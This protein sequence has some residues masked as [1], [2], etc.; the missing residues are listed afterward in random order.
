MNPPQ[1]IQLIIRTTPPPHKI[2]KESSSSSVEMAVLYKTSQKE[3]RTKE[4]S[5]SSPK[6]WPLVLLLLGCTFGSILFGSVHQNSSASVVVV[7]GLMVLAAVGVAVAVAVIGVAGLV[8]WI[9]VVVFLWLIGRSRRRL[10]A[11]G[12]K[13]SK[14]V[15]VGFMVRVLLKEGNV[16]GAISAA[17]FGYLGLCMGSIII[18]SYSKLFWLK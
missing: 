10:V 11:E 13:I 7:G 1:I 3:E 14:E 8:T 2:R 5:W 15:M 17:V 16:L 18:S 6:Q 12:R 9:T 4:P